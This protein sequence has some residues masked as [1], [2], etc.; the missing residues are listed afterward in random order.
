VESSVVVVG[1]DDT[2]KQP[3]GK[4]NTTHARAA[5]AIVAVLKSARTLGLLDSQNV[6]AVNKKQPSPHGERLPLP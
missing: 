2:G 1:E 4:K 5:S 6:N 3:A